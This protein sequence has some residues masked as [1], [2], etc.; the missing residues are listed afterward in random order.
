M[1]PVLLL[2]TVDLIAAT[3]VGTLR[4]KAQEI[5]LQK[6][7]EGSLSED[8]LRRLKKAKWFQEQVYRAKLPATLEKKFD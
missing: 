3:I 4:I 2:V 1:D 6:W 5:V 7:K 8:E